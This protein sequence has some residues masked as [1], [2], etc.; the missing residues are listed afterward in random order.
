MAFNIV[1]EV[2]GLASVTLPATAACAG[3]VVAFSTV[4]AV[5][6]VA[7]ASGFTGANTVDAGSLSVAF[8]AVVALS[9]SQ[10]V[11]G[12]FSSIF[13]L[14][15]VSG[16]TEAELKEVTASLTVAIAVVAAS[17]QEASFSNSVDGAITSGEE[18]ALGTV[19]SVSADAFSGVA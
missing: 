10:K 13:L 9:S 19:V 6:I 14:T 1:A 7:G 16:I 18:L 12:L 17:G 2:L 4:L 8:A 11:L 5:D 15:A 3:A